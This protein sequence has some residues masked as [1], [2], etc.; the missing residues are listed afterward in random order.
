MAFP[1]A[2]SHTCA[3]L[4]FVPRG[5]GAHEVMETCSPRP[6]QAHGLARTGAHEHMRF[7]SAV[8]YIRGN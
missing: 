2:L 5:L 6:W 8:D 3:T 4:Q 7:A 1:S